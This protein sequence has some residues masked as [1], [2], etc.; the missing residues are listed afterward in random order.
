ML[1]HILMHCYSCK[2]VFVN[3]I[4][5]GVLC[6]VLLWQPLLLIIM[7]DPIFKSA[8]EGDTNTIMDILDHFLIM[9]ILLNGYVI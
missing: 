2:I 5:C 6:I 4:I 8:E 7:E 9:S 3:V 1:L